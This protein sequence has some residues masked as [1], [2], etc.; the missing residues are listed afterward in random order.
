MGQFKILVSRS[1][2]SELVD[3]AVFIADSENSE[4]EIEYFS[5]ATTGCG[6]YRGHEQVVS[7][8]ARN[9]L[10]LRRVSVQVKRESS[11]IF[12]L[13]S[14]KKFILYISMILAFFFVM[15]WERRDI[16]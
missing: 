13:F 10:L 15:L 8:K 16:R 14:V 2:V 1:Q 4:L 9:M 11:F 6:G 3:Q 5:L 12:C 7:F